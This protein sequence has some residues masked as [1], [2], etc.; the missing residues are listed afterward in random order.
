[1]DVLASDRCRWDASDNGHAWLKGSKEWMATKEKKARGLGPEEES[2]GIKE[3]GGEW[4]RDQ[5]ECLKCLWWGWP[6]SW[7]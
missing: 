3:S 1:M 5:V 2:V 7:R 6:E 4:I